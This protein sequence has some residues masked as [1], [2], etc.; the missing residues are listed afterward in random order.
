MWRKKC[1]PGI[2]MRCHY[3]CNRMAKVKEADNTMCW[4]EYRATTT[5]TYSCGKVK[6]INHIVKSSEFLIKLN[7]LICYDPAVLFLGRYPREM[8]AYVHKKNLYNNISSNF[9][10][11]SPKL[12][13]QQQET[14]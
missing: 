8:K 7:T 5:L 11:N 12:V 10:L 1:V 2:T 9:I 4:Q 3:I 6:P 14:Q 13:V